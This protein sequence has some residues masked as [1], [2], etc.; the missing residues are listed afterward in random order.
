[1]SKRIVSINTPGIYLCE[2]DRQLEIW[3]NQ[4][5]LSKIPIEDL[6][7]L[8]IEN[9]SVTVTCRLFDSL[10]TAGVVVSICDSFHLPNSILLPAS[11]VALHA[12][13]TRALALLSKPK[14]KRIWQQIISAKIRL[15]ADV[16]TNHPVE[17]GQL[18][19]LSTTVISGD[20][21]NLEATAARTYWKVIFHEF[22]PSFT[23]SGD[24]V[25]NVYLNYGYSVV[26]SAVARGLVGAGFTP[27][28]GV[29]HDSRDNAFALADDLFEVFRPYVDL[30]ILNKLK[31]PGTLTDKSFKR[32]LLS[33]LTTNLSFGG[34]T[35]PFLAGIDRLISS[36]TRFVEGTTNRL[37]FPDL[38]E[39]R[40]ID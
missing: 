35:C 7:V 34:E 5:R 27:L 22:E 26:R 32:E 4:E 3:L 36:F 6:G 40:V 23:R 24:S 19:R 12:S 29:F 31:S 8:M 17:Q 37:E 39:F 25:I 30:M 9:H 15:Q 20:N 1:M 14:K 16:L 10:A 11:G 2:K 38:C 21:S 33:I 28:F 13:R 18:R